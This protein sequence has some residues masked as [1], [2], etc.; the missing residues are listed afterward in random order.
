MCA[1]QVPF[2][3]LKLAPADGLDQP[4]EGLKGAVSLL[5]VL[6]E[7]AANSRRACSTL[8]FSLCDCLPSLFTLCHFSFVNDLLH[9]MFWTATE[10]A[11]RPNNDETSEMVTISATSGRG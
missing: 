10:T 11:C 6:G 5:G 2:A 4:T 3:I 9:E 7:M 8:E 1:S